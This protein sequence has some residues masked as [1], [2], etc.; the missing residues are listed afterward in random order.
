MLAGRNVVRRGSLGTDIEVAELVVL[1]CL[2]VC[3][4]LVIRL[5]NIERLFHVAP[6]RDTS[7]HVVVLLV[8]TCFRLHHA[9][10]MVDSS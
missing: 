9:R 3:G 5:V 7:W 2:Q 10:S 1:R 6:G 4:L 8:S